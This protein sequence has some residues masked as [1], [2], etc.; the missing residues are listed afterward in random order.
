MSSPPRP[1]ETLRPAIRAILAIAALISLTAAGVATTAVAH[2]TAGPRP[3]PA[4][5]G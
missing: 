1:S 4:V 3:I 2:V 5:E